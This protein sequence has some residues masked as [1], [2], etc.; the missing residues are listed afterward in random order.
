[1]TTVRQG[2]RSLL[3]PTAFAVAALAILA[4]L[5]T[6][7][8]R[9]L[10]WK[11][12]LI[13]DATERST[14]AP[15]PAPIEADWT[16]LD[17]TQTEYRHVALSGTF[18]HQDE[19]HVFTDLPDAK[20]PARGIGYWVLTPLVQDDGSIV[21]INRGFV[22]KGREDPATRPEGQVGGRAAVTGLMR[23][24]E[25]RNLFTPAD[26]PA[27]GEW[28]TRDTAAIGAARGLDRVAPFYVDADAS[29]PG[30]LPQGGETRLVFPNRHLEYALTWY[31]L[32][33]ALVAV[34]GV[35]A[36]RRWTGR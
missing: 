26:T 15:Q 20:G 36:W 30:G 17:R 11:E 7:Q 34:Y 35:F 8:L 10:V 13:R 4:A 32:G 14:Q 2:E 1:M 22:P 23:W 27:K 3:W 28:Y 9:R 31:G 33:G 5:G 25:E 29:P 6:W 12:G 24:S 21:L 19:V 16:R 18:R